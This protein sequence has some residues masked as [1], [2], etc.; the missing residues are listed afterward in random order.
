MGGRIATQV[1]AADAEL[2]LAGLVLLGYPLHP[3]GRP[4]QTARC[5]SSSRRA[6]D[7]LRAR[8]PRRIRDAGG[9]RADSRAHRSAADD[10]R[11]RAAAITRSSCQDA[12]R[13]NRRAM[14]E[15]IQHAIVRWMA[16]YRCRIERMRRDEKFLDDAAADEVLLDDAL[17]HRR[18]ALRRT[19]RLPDRRPRSVRLRKSAGSWLSCA[20][21]RPD[22]T[23]RAP[24]DVS[25]GSPRRQCRSPCRSTS[26]SSDR[27]RE[28]YAAARPARR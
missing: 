4:E 1:A 18:I 3:P 8:Q 10:A 14:Y 19:T 16:R 23:A 15:E 20:G 27:R 26:A 25:S 5:P 12:I 22:R 9:T 28:K 13:R 6:A 11:S 7:A 17:E 24:S 21:C 2:P